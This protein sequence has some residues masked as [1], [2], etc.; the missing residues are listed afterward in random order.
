VKR[1]D[2]AVPVRR[3]EDAPEVTINIAH[4]IERRWPSAISRT[5]PETNIAGDASPDLGHI[6]E[7]R[8]DSMGLLKTRRNPF[9]M[10]TLLSR[11]RGES[12]R[13]SRLS[14]P[15]RSNRD[16]ATTSAQRVMNVIGSSTNC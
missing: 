10:Q 15:A 1:L 8:Q 7:Q 6:C 11:F 12:I 13:K 9:A 3:V 2:L 4:R 14:N 5:R 16:D